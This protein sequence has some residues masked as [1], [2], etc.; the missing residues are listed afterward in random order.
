VRAAETL[1]TFIS[2]VYLSTPEYIRKK[3]P[4]ACDFE[5]LSAL[6]CGN[7]LPWKKAPWVNKLNGQ[8]IR[9]VNLG[10]LFVLQRWMLTGM[11]DWDGTGITDQLSFSQH[12]G[13]FGI[14]ETLTDHWNNW[15]QPFDFEQMAAAGLNSVRIPVG[16]WYFEELSGLAPLAP[17]P[18]IKPSVSIRDAS[19]PIT[20][21]IALAKASGLQ[22]ILVQDAVTLDSLPFITVDDVAAITTKTAVAIATYIGALKDNFDLGNVILLEIGTAPDL[23]DTVAVKTS[24]S[25]IRA[26]FPNLPV[27]FLEHSSVASSILSTDSNVFIDTN[28]YHGTSVPDIASDTAA[29]D[30]EKMFAHEKIACKCA[31]VSSPV[32]YFTATLICSY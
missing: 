13:D 12:C 10:G 5:A 8:P 29:A 7:E 4:G 25:G 31:C 14:C 26:T 6:T 21:I 17:T 2:S 22:V 11:F 1:S 15:Y 16:F 27:M 24:I 23:D 3:D 19:H 32:S 9:A 20:R 28:V 18:Y 30:R